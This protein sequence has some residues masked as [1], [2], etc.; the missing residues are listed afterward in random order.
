MDKTPTI[1]HYLITNVIENNKQF[2]NKVSTSEGVLEMDVSATSWQYVTTDHNLKIGNKVLDLIMM[3]RQADLN[4]QMD[5]TMWHCG[6]C[7][8]GDHYID[9]C[10]QLQDVANIDEQ[11]E[12]GVFQNH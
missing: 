10:P 4:Q 6:L 11:L 8:V 1:A 2:N 3:M 5:G 9:Q 7:A 12:V